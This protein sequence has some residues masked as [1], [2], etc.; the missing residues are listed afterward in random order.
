DELVAI[1]GITQVD[2]RNVRSYEISIEVSE[3]DLRRYALTFDDVVQ[4]VR[5]SSVDL[6]GGAI[7]T[8]KGEI[9]LRS[10]GQAYTGR[11]FERIVI[12]TRPDGTRLRIADVAEVNDGF[13]E[14]ARFA[15]F[16]GERAVLIQ[17][18]RIGDQRVL[19]LVEKVKRYT[20]TAEAWLP[21]G[22]ELTVWRDRST[23]LRDRLDILVRNGLQGFVLVFLLLAFFLRLRLAFWVSVGVPLS[24]LA[25][26]VFFPATGVSINVISLFAFIMV[27]GLLV[28]DAIVVG[29]NVHSHQERAEDPLEAA[30]RGTQEVSVPV[31]FGVLTT[32]AAFLPLVTADGMMGQVF[33]EIGLVVVFCLAFSVI[34]S[35][36]ILPAHLSHSHAPARIP[37]EGSVR[38]RWKNAQDRTSG[39]LV[40]VAKN[41]YRPWLARALEWRYTTI[42]IGIMALL[43]TIAIL[44]SGRMGFTFMPKVESNYVTAGL[45]MPLGVPVEFTADAVRKLE[46]SAQRIKAELDRE[47][48]QEDASVV[49]HI[50]ASVG[51]RPSG[52]SRHGGGA[53]RGSA[54]SS[55]IGEVSLELQRPESRPVDASEV[56]RRWRDATPA[57]PD[58]VELTFSASLFSAGDPVAVRLQ[59]A[60]I[61]DL[62][63]AAEELK[64]RLTEYPGI[65]EIRDSF[66]DGKEEIKLS[67]LP[68]A[69]LLGLSL[70][71][72]GRQVRQAFYGAQAQRVQRG[73]DE[74]RVMVRY[75]E[76]E[77]RSQSDLEGMRIRTPDGDEVPFDRVARVES[78][79]GYSSIRRTNRMRV[80]NVKADVDRSIANSNEIMADL[81][82]NVLPQLLADHP[83]L[84]YELEGEQREQSKVLAGM[85]R[86]FGLC[87]V[88]IYGLLAVPLRSYS[89]PLIIMAV[90]PFGLVGA[91]AGHLL[92]GHGLSMMSVFGVVALAGVVVNASL[93]MVH[94]I[95]S[96]RAIGIPLVDA[97]RDAGVARFRPIVLTSLTTFVGLTP[98]LL[99]KSISAQF[100]IPMAISLAFGVALATTVTLFLV[101]SAYLVLE[102][103]RAIASRI[104]GRD[105][106]GDP[107]D[108]AGDIVSIGSSRAS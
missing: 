85:L 13:E 31:I 45:E 23:S 14:D 8:S 97:V 70:Q 27:L 87:L 67:I 91:I 76:A 88:L 39:L 34:E 63:L 49:K 18:Y 98:L 79:V 37:R 66:R 40:N 3:A 42:A 26:L 32:V 22:L 54:G 4:A 52:E 9:L 65:Y 55:H 84:H 36:L 1:D 28:D 68:S 30:I 89:Q 56:E 21:E 82:S 60:D 81:R 15:R 62:R 64:S 53:S 95:N 106:P 73:R 20:D 19:D 75:P 83:G 74:L 46:A 50:L 80:L 5:R 77:R 17:V 48:P 86:D 43:W 107:G 6:P 90:I 35:Q 101:P 105:E 93:V 11:D 24:F 38:A 25:A 72:L 44:V 99:E 104:F 103:V 102:D 59:S 41:G 7:K 47:F 78:G 96:R 61:E 2:L 92:M 12:L 33:S 58:A 51:G 100:L 71:D 108:D 69:E 10:K 16:D 94:Y 29:E 57:I